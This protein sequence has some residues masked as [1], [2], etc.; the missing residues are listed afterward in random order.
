M[1]YI[2]ATNQIPHRLKWSYCSE[3]NRDIFAKLLIITPIIYGRNSNIFV[4]IIHDAI[5]LD[6]DTVVE[7]CT[8]RSLAQGAKRFVVICS[9]GISQQ[10]ASCIS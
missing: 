5:A 7:D 2:L 4:I 1:I 9:V 8:D 3:T 10:I 6:P